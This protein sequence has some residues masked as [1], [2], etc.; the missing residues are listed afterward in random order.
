M[1]PPRTF[2]EKKRKSDEFKDGHRKIIPFSANITFKGEAALERDN[3]DR[4][5]KKS[6][7]KPGSQLN[8]G[9]GKHVERTEDQQKAKDRFQDL[10]K[11]IIEDPDNSNLKDEM[12]TLKD[13]YHFRDSHYRIMRAQLIRNG[14]TSTVT[15]GDIKKY[16]SESLK[17]LGFEKHLKDYIYKDIQM[18][19]DGLL[20]ANAFMRR[21]YIV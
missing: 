20:K 21:C 15:S 3:N 13:Q 8:K 18:V 4:D 6:K 12:N 5:Q 7:R 1:I 19:N 17:E 16:L 9:K 2:K 11:Q 10:K 14:R